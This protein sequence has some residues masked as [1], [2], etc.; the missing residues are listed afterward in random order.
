M[1]RAECI[2]RIG[3]KTAG[4]YGRCYSTAHVHCSTEDL[5]IP[6]CVLNVFLHQLCSPFPFDS[7]P[8][9]LFSLLC[10]SRTTPPGWTQQTST[11]EWRSWIRPRTPRKDQGRRARRASGKSSTWVCLF[12]WRVPV[13]GE[14][15][16]H[17]VVGC[18]LRS[19]LNLALLAWHKNV[20]SP[21]ASTAI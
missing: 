6:E 14:E 21:H 19:Q 3:L 8:S 13:L 9:V 1:E 17:R 2:V 7:L 15:H 18:L 10:S 16:C 11:P 5:K 20:G 4:D 12:F